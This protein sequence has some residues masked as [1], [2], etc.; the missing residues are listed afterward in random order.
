MST[1]TWSSHS[2]QVCTL[3]PGTLL[4]FGDGFS[5]LILTS[6]ETRAGNWCLRALVQYRGQNSINEYEYY[7]SHMFSCDHVFLP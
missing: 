4:F 2:L 3:T 5:M 7:S 6:R 1:A